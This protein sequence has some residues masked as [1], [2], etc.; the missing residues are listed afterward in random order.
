MQKNLAGLGNHL[1]SI[2]DSRSF[3]RTVIFCTQK[4]V[5]S[6]IFKYQR[7][8]AKHKKYV[9]M[10]HSSLSVASKLE[11]YNEFSAQ[12]SNICVLVATIAFGMVS[13]IHYY[14]DV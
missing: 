11:I 3:P 2:C 7:E 14:K 1:R 10:Y 12:Q 8:C 6:N 4:N 5:L 9:A 13:C